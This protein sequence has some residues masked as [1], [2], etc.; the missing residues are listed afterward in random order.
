MVL[1]VV[2]SVTLWMQQ[3]CTRMYKR[4]V[5][6]HLRRRDD[7]FRC[8]RC[9][10][11]RRHWRGVELTRL[12]WGK[13]SFQVS[14]R[15]KK[16]NESDVIMLQYR[17]KVE[18]KCLS[19]MIIYALEDFCIFMKFLNLYKMIIWL[20]NLNICLKKWL[21]YCNCWYLNKYIE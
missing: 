10:V 19:L 14:A 11:S 4:N 12:S 18:W 16:T 9:C 15:Q 21:C 3:L 8:E 7:Q 1:A 13:M 2:A 6:W 5:F 17:L 20:I